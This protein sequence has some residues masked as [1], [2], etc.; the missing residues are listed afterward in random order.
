MALCTTHGLVW[1]DVK[2]TAD[3][4]GGNFDVEATDGSGI[5]ARNVPRRR[6]K[7][8][9]QTPPK[10]LQDGEPVDAIVNA[11]LKAASVVRTAD[12]VPNAYDLKLA[13]GSA[14]AHVPRDQ[15]LATHE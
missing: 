9:D 1:I 14:L 7:L 13:D 8:P 6:L 12:G 15:I 10:L 5:C 2:V 11:S 4:A 3:A